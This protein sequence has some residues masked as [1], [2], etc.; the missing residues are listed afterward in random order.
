MQKERGKFIV[1]DGINNLGKSTQVTQLANALIASGI[2]VKTLKYH[3]YD[4]FLGD[5][6]YRIW[7]KNNPDNFSPFICQTLAYANKSHFQPQL[8]KMLN[9]GMWIIAENYSGTSIAWGTA[10]GVPFAQMEELQKSLIAPDLTILLDG[11]RYVEAVESGH[12]YENDDLKQKH[13]REIFLQLADK[14]GW[15]KV[16]ANQSIEQVS[17]DIWEIVSN[18]CIN[19]KKEIL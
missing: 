9:E 14:Y 1:I 18:K 13:C 8:E 16:K 12:L 6:C 4:E 15:S 3:L 2:P 10:D 5:V 7:H 11:E 19:N 17:N